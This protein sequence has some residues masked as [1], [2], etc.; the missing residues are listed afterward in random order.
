VKE[1][2]TKR[3]SAVWIV[4]SGG[5]LIAAVVIA[6][7]SPWLRICDVR[8]VIVSGNQHV[9]AAELVSLSRLHRGQTVFSVPAGLVQQRL[10]EVPW[11]KHAAVRRRFPHTIELAI[12]ERQ[13][14]AWVEQPS[15]THR[16]AIGEG[17]VI[18]GRDVDVTSSL[19]LVGAQLSG[20]NDG[21]RVV[22]PQVAELLP[23][24][25]GN[26]CGF[27]VERVD[28]TDLRSIDLFL[29]NDTRVRLGDITL[30]RARLTELEALCREIQIDGYELIDVRFG[31]EATLVPRKAVRR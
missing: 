26:V 5:V 22:E 31:G 18:V 3:Q 13:V 20:W 6:L 24:L 4:I 7:Y 30:I 9:S 29:E 15:E 27:A 23:T 11:V 10:E 21:D 28:V 14:V 8:Q 19:E 1:G 17:G 12:E 25:Q 16:L 2:N